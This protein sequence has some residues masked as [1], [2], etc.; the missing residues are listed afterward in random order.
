MRLP[1]PISISLKIASLLLAAAFLYGLWHTSAFT[2]PN[3]PDDDDIQV[4]PRVLV[5]TGKITRGTVRSHLN[6]FGT[7]EPA[8]AHGE[9]PAASASISLPAGTRI[10]HV[11]CTEGSLVAKDQ[12]LLTLNVRAVS[13]AAA[14]ASLVLQAAND[15]LDRIKKA[16]ASGTVPQRDLLKAQHEVDLAEAAFQDAGRRQSLS[17]VES[18]LI[19]TVTEL[20]VHPGDVINST[21][22]VITI[23]DLQRLVVAVSVPADELSK[24]LAGQD[25]ELTFTRGHAG[26]PA[27]QPTSFLTKVISIDP[28]VDAATGMG[29]VDVL[30]PPVSRLRPGDFVRVR[31]VTA[32][33]NDVLLAPVDSIV[34][35]KQGQSGISTV[36]RDFHWADRVP[37][38]TGI[39]DGDLIEISGDG[40]KEGQDIVTVGAYAL[41]DKSQIDV[42][43]K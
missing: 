4:A 19:G 9:V 7:V 31:I 20:S 24:V 5:Q 1:P 15:N 28:A 27:T 39:R 26:A 43:V 3:A 34:A 29:S 36:V 18:P 10:D 37:V 2:I 38:Q 6:V 35:N 40:I 16:A 11:N 25:A 32:E 41:P 8:P 13:N 17:D 30:V 23:V 33:H 12:T 42:A 14:T 21:H 22:S